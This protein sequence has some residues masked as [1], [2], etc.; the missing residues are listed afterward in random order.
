MLKRIRIDKLFN[1]Y[2]YDIDLSNPDGSLVKFITAPNGY[3]KTTILE[4]I[5]ATMRQSYDV[6][7]DIPFSRFDLF[8]EDD[9][10]TLFSY[11]VVRKDI[12]SSS[13][14]SDLVQAVSKQLFIRLKR[15]LGG[16][17]SLL[18]Y[19]SLEQSSSGSFIIRGNT[20]DIQMFFVSRTCFYL[21]DDRLLRQKKDTGEGLL[22]LDDTSISS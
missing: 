18:G 9:E 16:V 5:D 22:D 12:Y 8:F 19:Y 17:E 14:E 4:L 6:M 13:S 7:F 21:T 1:V 20:N 3:G 2:T 10:T 15:I 11:S